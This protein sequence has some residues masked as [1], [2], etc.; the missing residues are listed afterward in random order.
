MKKQQKYILKVNNPC[1][2]EWASM[3]KTD[4]GKFCSYCSKTVI[5]FTKLTDSE[6]IQIVEQNSDKLCGRLTKQQLNRPLKIN[7]PTNGSQLYKILGGLLLVGTTENSLATNQLFP[8][9]EIVSVTENETLPVQQVKPEE[10]L[11]TE[12]SLKNVIQGIVL[13]SRTKEPL[14]F[15]IVFIK[16]TEIQVMTDFDG[17]FKL[18]IPDNLLKRV[19]S[20]MITPL[21]YEKTEIVIRKE[22]L[23][24]VEKTIIVSEEQILIGAIITEKKKWWKFW[25]RQ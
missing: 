14:P 10:E 1:K 3:T 17:K 6:I 7:Q 12:D 22:D 13:D 19:M 4:I 20:L 5:D 18:I 8:Q 25:K 11:K 9:T 21:G 2:Q 24:I 16:N 23:P 15:T